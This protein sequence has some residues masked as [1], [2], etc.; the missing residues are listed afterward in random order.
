MSRRKAGSVQNKTRGGSQ[1]SKG[2]KQRSRSRRKARSI[3][4]KTRG[5]SQKSKG[6]KQ[7][8]RSRRKARSDDERKATSSKAEHNERRDVTVKAQYTNQNGKRVPA[9]S[10]SQLGCMEGRGGE[11]GGSDAATAAHLPLAAAARIA[12][13]ASAAQHQRILQVHITRKKKEKNK[14]KKKTG[15]SLAVSISAKTP[16]HLTRVL[17][18][19]EEV[20][21]LS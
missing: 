19:N 9:H 5:G 13:I 8:S 16:T 7:K 3:Q 4:N 14:K 12:G 2:E 21:G 20:V 15:G 17:K 1:K 18:N 6:E 10:R 11:G